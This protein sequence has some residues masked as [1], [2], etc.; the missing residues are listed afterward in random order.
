MKGYVENIEKITLTNEN[1]RK[2][3]YTSKN[4]QLVLMSLLPGEEIGLEVHNESDQFFRIESGEGMVII[5]GAESSLIDGVAVIVPMGAS[6][7]IVNTGTT[8][9]KIYTLY[10]PPHH[11]EGTVHATKADEAGDDEHFDGVTTE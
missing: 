1:Y 5:D 10:M 3:L 7:N 4:C 8:M 11:R 9:M 6:H 2:V